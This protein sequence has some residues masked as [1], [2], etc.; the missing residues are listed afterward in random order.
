MSGEFVHVILRA[1]VSAASPSSG[2]W[3]HPRY[4]FGHKTCPF[5]A[6]RFVADLN[7]MY[8]P[9]YLSC[10]HLSWKPLDR[11]RSLRERLLSVQGIDELPS[12]PKPS[13]QTNR[14]S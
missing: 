6:P 3:A 7:R 5:S 9:A 12:P 13:S 11:K 2:R 1:T 4:E 14:I 10:R 8:L